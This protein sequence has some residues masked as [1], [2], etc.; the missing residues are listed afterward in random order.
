MSNKGRCKNQKTKMILHFPKEGI[1]IRSCSIQNGKKIMFDRYLQHPKCV[2]YTFLCNVLLTSHYEWLL[3]LARTCFLYCKMCMISENEIIYHNEI[4]CLISLNYCV[5]TVNI[6]TSYLK[7]F[8]QFVQ[9][10]K[11]IP[12][13]NIWRQYSSNI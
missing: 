4:C 3:N 12:S 6:T 10:L 2:S 11:Y 8:F 5:C 13:V 9:S 1:S 7:V